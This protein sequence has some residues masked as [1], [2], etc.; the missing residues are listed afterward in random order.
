MHCNVRPPIGLGFNYEAHN[1]PIDVARIFS[2]GARFTSEKVDDLFVVALKTQAK[3][4]KLTTPH[5]S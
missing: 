1:I 5:P 4:T 2:G 3:T